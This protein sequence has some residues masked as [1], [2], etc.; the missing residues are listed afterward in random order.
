M[1]RRLRQRKGRALG[2]WWRHRRAETDAFRCRYINQT[3]RREW[4]K[5][6]GYNRAPLCRLKRPLGKSLLVGIE[7]TTSR[8]AHCLRSKRRSAVSTLPM[9]LRRLSG[10]VVLHINLLHTCKRGYCSFRVDV[11]LSAAIMILGKWNL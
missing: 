3:V 4:G 10:G 11:P 9:T 2:V 8:V 7:R 5:S 6:F 1:F